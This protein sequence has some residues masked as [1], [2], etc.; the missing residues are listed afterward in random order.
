MKSGKSNTKVP[1]KRIITSFTSKNG[2]TFVQ[3][4]SVL[5]LGRRWA[6]MLF[7][8]GKEKTNG[9]VAFVI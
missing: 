7:V 1:P 2:K 6:L 9:I 8:F 4:P 3:N 5:G